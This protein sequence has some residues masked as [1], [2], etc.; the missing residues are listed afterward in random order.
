MK[1][2]TINIIVT[3]KKSIT[4]GQL[5]VAHTLPFGFDVYATVILRNSGFPE[6]TDSTVLTGNIQP[7]WLLF[8]EVG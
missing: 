4:F 5:F 3:M 6:I 8:L 2:F 7:R 1:Q